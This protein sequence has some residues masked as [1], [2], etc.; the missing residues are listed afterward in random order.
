[1]QKLSAI[2]NFQGVRGALSQQGHVYLRQGITSISQTVSF[3][4]LYP[5]VFSEEKK[6]FTIYNKENLMDEEYDDTELGRIADE[7]IQ[8]FQADSSQVEFIINSS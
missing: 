7:R 3:S 2:V 8:S 4:K 1:M 6:S 5:W